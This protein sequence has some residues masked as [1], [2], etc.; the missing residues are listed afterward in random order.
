MLKYCINHVKSLNRNSS[1]E[2]LYV[3]LNNDIEIEIINNWQIN[4]KALLANDHENKFW[5]FSG[6]LLAQMN[7]KY[8]RS[9]ILVSQM[10]FKQI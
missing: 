2:N 8:Q 10:N 3:V 9:V 7:F 6:A 1:I 4:Y 5:K